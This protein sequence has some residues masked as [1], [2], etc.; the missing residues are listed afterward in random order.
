[1][2]DVSGESLVP[3]ICDVVESGSEIQTD[4]WGG[5][6]SLNEQRY[7][8]SRTVL[9]QSGDPAHVTTRRLKNGCL[10]NNRICQ[11]LSNVTG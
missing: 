6:N 1:M 2:P 7:T 11:V 4:G 8:H 5:Y 3:F 10:D 9:S